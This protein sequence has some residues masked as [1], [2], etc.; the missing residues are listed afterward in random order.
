V[1]I[2]SGSHFPANDITSYFF[3]AER[4]SIVNTNHIFFIYLLG[5]R[6]LGCFQNLAVE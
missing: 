1:M 2:S 5:D 4:Y 6:H 3:M